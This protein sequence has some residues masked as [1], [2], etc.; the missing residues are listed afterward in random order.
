M[1]NH[2]HM[3]TRRAGSDRLR[4]ASRSK[5]DLSVI[6]SVARSIARKRK[7]AVNTAHLMLACIDEGGDASNV[8][9]S[10]LATREIDALLAADEPALILE[11]V[12]A[13]VRRTPEPPSAWEVM[14]AVLA[15]QSSA[16]VRGLEAC[17]A[18]VA[19]LRAIFVGA[20]VRD[21]WVPRGAPPAASRAWASNLPVGGSRGP[22]H[23]SS[24][25]T[26]SALHAS[27]T[28]E[29]LEAASAVE[30][31]LDRAITEAR[32]SKKPKA[33]P[34]TSARTSTST[35]ESPDV[36]TRATTNAIERQP[37][38][39]EKFPILTSIGRDLTL[40]S[41]LAEHLVLRPQL[42]EQVIDATERLRSPHALLVGPSGAGKTSLIHVLAAR[43]RQDRPCD[44]IFEITTS[45]L[46][47]STGV[48]GAITEKMKKLRAEIQR[49]ERRVIL[50]LDDTHLA[51]TAPTE[52]GDDLASELKSL[53]ASRICTVI[54]A[55][56]EQDFK[57]FMERDPVLGR[58]FTRVDIAEPESAECLAMVT[59]AAV[60]LVQHHGIPISE[61]VTRSAIESAK[62]YATHRA[63]PD[64]AISILD[65]AS[66]RARRLQRAE[67]D[68]ECIAGVVAD[69][70][71]VP[72]ERVLSS[73]RE[74]L[75]ALDA[76]LSER[77]VG[78]RDAISRIAS[79]LRRASVGFR[80]NRPLGSF[81]LLG[82]TGVG[83]TE[84]ARAIADSLFT[85]A[86]VTR[87][88]M[89]E[90]AESHSIARLLGAPPGYLGHEDG[91]QL[92]E[93]VRRRPYQLLLFD[94][95]EKAHPDVLLALLS[96][97]EDGRLTDSR[98]RTV[99]FAETVV[100]MTSNLGAE[101][102][103]TRASVGFGT[104]TADN[105]D[106]DRK[107]AAEKRSE[108]AISLVRKALPP[109]FF[110]RIDE[111]LF[112]APLERDS[113]MNVARQLLE[114]VARVARESHGI[115]LT[116]DDSSVE[117]LIEN[118]GYEPSLGARP[119]RRAIARH[120]EAPL[121]DLL[122]TG[123]FARGTR[124]NALADSGQVRFDT[125]S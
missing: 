76:A 42:V 124:L 11:D 55:T 96:V 6:L 98:G 8:L 125:S 17:G 4:T 2:P 15:R 94:E 64:S 99:D 72:K 36:A 60:R 3:T 97:L 35:A 40:V 44:A 73:D 38:D 43:L 95:I 119:M 49:L 84:T 51:F 50:V 114:V 80:G 29:V 86:N 70:A 33:T 67:V 32:R 121:A 37:L 13:Q 123:A 83:K 118:G 27:S 52:T 93:S 56:S 9:R 14:R 107:S 53:L 5:G 102:A 10:F 81:L 58:R 108:H 103:V 59:A 112:Y 22:S 105:D 47:A 19:R 78:Q 85:S 20:P 7:V 54:G 69:V 110:N 66:A 18:D 89:S 21:S 92:T 111:V 74:R 12:L 82:P 79:H 23:A 34:E 88:D 48:R 104:R 16:V 39:P 122:I 26:R 91:G 113:I 25:Q 46:L 117:F 30:S 116:F 120:V 71:R 57:R 100:V 65:T 41:D 109:E 62:R 75:V 24:S 63:L 31:A 68:L 90:F 1:P 61:S 77:I 115:E 87:F 28:V 45:A 106:A 101:A